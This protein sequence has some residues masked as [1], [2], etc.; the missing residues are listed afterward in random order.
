M[1]MRILENP[2]GAGFGVRGP[3]RSSGITRNKKDVNLSQFRKASS[4]ILT[5]LELG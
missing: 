3:W 4:M 2:H 1:V 5:G